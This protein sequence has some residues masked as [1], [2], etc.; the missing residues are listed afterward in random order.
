[1]RLSK[2]S[3]IIPIRLMIV[4]LNRIK[5]WKLVTLK[6]INCLIQSLKYRVLRKSGTEKIIPE[7][8]SILY[9]TIT[10]MKMLNS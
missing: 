8:L 7:N 5:K 9:L 1:M 6:R 2:I 4:K 3:S 10:K